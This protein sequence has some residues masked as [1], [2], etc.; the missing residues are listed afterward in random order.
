LWLKKIKRSTSTPPPSPP[1][2]LLYFNVKNHNAAKT[3]NLFFLES[4]W[5]IFNPKTCLE[6][7]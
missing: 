3:L 4:T 2:T 1:H 7:T 6:S 5:T